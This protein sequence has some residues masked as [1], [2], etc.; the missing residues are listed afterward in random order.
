MNRFL[1]GVADFLESRPRVAELVDL[2][3]SALLPHR[4]AVAA[5][6]GQDHTICYTQCENCYC[7]AGPCFG[8][9]CEMNNWS[10]STTACSN[11]QVSKL[12]WTGNCCL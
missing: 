3:G 5:G 11:H 9:N 4:D 7:N 12:T 8:F 2:L 6:C 1:S 10:V